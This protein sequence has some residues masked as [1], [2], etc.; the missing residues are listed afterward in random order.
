[1]DAILRSSR[2]TPGQR[3]LAEALARGEAAMGEQV[4]RLSGSNYTDPERY[5]REL[6]RLFAR[7]PL[8]LCR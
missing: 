2:P 7:L 1:M 4:V 3:A 8:L 5:D 6:A